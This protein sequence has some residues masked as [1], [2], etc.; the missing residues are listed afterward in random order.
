MGLTWRAVSLQTEL[1]SY[2]MEFAITLCLTTNILQFGVW[3][4]SQTKPEQRSF[5]G[6]RVTVPPIRM[7]WLP[8]W[9]LGWAVPLVCAQPLA[10]MIIYTF[11]MKE[12]KMWKDGSWWPNTPIGQ[13][14]LVCSYFGFLFMSTGVMLVTKMDKK[15]SE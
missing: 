2:G 11:G 9:L 6:G 5:F 7:K 10:I 14:L 13:T 8:A 15:V 12:A 4:C 1:F 3:K